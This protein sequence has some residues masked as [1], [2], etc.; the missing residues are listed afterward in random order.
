MADKYL[1]YEG[2]SD[3]FKSGD[4]VFVKDGAPAAVD[5]STAEALLELPV[6]S[7][8]VVNKSDAKKELAGGEP[9]VADE[10]A[11]A[12][13]EEA[14][15]RAAYQGAGTYAEQQAAIGKSVP[16]EPVAPSDADFEGNEGDSFEDPGEESEDEESEET[17][18]A[19]PIPE[20]DFQPG[21]DE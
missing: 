4:V 18:D 5:S 13:A 16:E 10:V 12:Y 2:P 19:P 8:E 21:G 9:E 20:P 1:R 14:R 7:F 6:D 15:K 17:P 11:E 3:R